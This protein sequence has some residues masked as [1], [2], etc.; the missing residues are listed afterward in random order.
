MY[1]E[2]YREFIFWYQGVKG[3]MS[4]KGNLSWTYYKYLVMLSWL[5]WRI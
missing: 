5:F 4:V 3:E 1:G 2:E